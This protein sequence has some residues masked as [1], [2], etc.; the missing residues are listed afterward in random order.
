M[1]FLSPVVD[2]PQCG[3]MSAVCVA[4]LPTASR[5]SQV[6]CPRPVVDP[7]DIALSCVVADDYTPALALQDV[8]AFP[9]YK[10][11]TLYSE[12]SP[13]HRGLIEEAYLNRGIPFGPFFPTDNYAAV[14]AV[15]AQ[16]IVPNGD[17]FLIWI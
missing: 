17:T 6:I 7:A 16:H 8:F 4:M 13:Y 3:I 9:D 1:I 10:P 2:D 12:V 15:A 11:Y 5:L 14:V